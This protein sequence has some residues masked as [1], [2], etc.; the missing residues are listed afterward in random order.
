[1][2]R[3]ERDVCQMRRAEEYKYKC[4]CIALLLF[5][6]VTVKYYFTRVCV[7]RARMF[8]R[9][10]TLSER[11]HSFC[12]IFRHFAIYLAQTTIQAGPHIFSLSK[13]ISVCFR[14]I[15]SVSICFGFFCVCIPVLSLR[16]NVSAHISISARF[17]LF[18]FV[19][20]GSRQSGDSQKQLN[21]AKWTNLIYTSRV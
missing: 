18:L 10:A 15:D 4:I 2:I 5:A 21:S 12:V 16:T 19:R 9:S 1:M 17:S 20:R 13:F 3:Y 7:M 8:A 11:S 14:F 6:W